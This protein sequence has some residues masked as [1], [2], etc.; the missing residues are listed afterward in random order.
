MS[1]PTTSESLA[2]PGPAPR[3]QERQRAL[4]GLL[5]PRRLLA[6]LPDACRKLDPRVMVRNPVMFVVEVG[7]LLTTLEA[8]RDPSVFAWVITAWLWLTVVFANLSEAVAEGRGKAQAETLRRTRTATV[9]RRLTGWSPGGSAAGEPAAEEEVPASSL[10]L[11]DHV[12]VEAGQTIPGDG[13]VVEG[14]ASVDES[15]ITGESAPVIRESGGDRC[16]VTGGT[17]VLSD[18]IVVRIT[19]KPGETFIDRMIALVEGAARQRTPNEIA[20]NI[21]LASLTVVFLLA[22]V[23]L[24]PFAVYAG[25]E[26][27]LVILVAL[28]VALIPTTIGALLS[29]IGIAGMDRLVQRN[30]LAMSGRAVEAA[31]DVSTLLLD[32]TGTITLGNRQAAGFLPVRGVTERELADAAQ[33]ASL[34]DET[35]EGRSIVVLAKQLHGLRE[36][37]E[38]RLPRAEFVP[39]TAQTRMSGVDL[40][41]DGGERRLRKGAAA[42]VLRWVRDSGGVVAEDVGPMVDAIAGGGGTPLV[43]G[44][45]V[46]RDG[47][48][49]ASVLGVINLKDVV[50]EGMRERFDELRRMGIRTVMITGDNPLT[51]K[52]IAEEAG[53]DDFLAEATPEDKMALIRREQ[54]GGKLV[55]MTGDGTNDAPAL[56]QADVGVAMNTGTSAAKE[57]GNMVD[58]DSN[59]TKL[60]EIVEIGKQLLIT[61]GALT[62]FSIANDVAKYFAIIPAM[63]AGVYPGLRHLNVMDLHSPTSAITSAIVFNALIIVALIP[64]ALRGV[65]YRPSSASALLS[66]NIR[67]YGLG[68]LVLPFAGIKLIDLVVQFIPGLR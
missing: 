4:G 65:R 56:A 46:R 43:V 60:I 57:A 63:F 49:T 47:A 44:E 29:A 67:V 13:D 64:L 2:A 33:L 7:S 36:G 21:L 32:K 30:V 35:P 53:V 24:Q 23:T 20:L 52:A 5:D 39:F 18:R 10:R 55:A 61:R 1:S 66:R 68:G 3:R 51:A 14:V 22:V 27:S 58:L 38:G 37:A 8:V 28:V 31:G 41:E 40:A 45:V 42:A 62:T 11:G 12:V 48:A 16:A 25:A 26:Q 50:K 9:A 17:S 59:P 54:A 34:A 15:A 19:S 6:S